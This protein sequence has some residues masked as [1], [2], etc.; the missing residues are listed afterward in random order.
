MDCVVIQ[1]ELIP[2]HFG[3]LGA[4]ERRSVEE[5]LPGCS[6]CLR[7][8]LALKREIETNESG[9]LPSAASRQRLRAAVAQELGTERRP[10]SWWERPLAF[11]AA[12]A[13]VVLAVVSLHALEPRGGRP[14]PH[15]ADR[16]SLG[17]HE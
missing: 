5:H 8:Y 15:S 9:P 3:D 7:G 16:Q 12:A 17:A 1:G 6:R 13:A 14:S 4:E 11:A 10:W 2:F